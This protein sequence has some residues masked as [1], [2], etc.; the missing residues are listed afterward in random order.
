MLCAVTAASPYTTSLARTTISAKKPQPMQSTYSA[1][2]IL[3][4]RRA[5]VSGISVWAIYGLRCALRGGLPHDSSDC[6]DGDQD[7]QKH[8][9]APWLDRCDGRVRPPS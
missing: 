1:P 9:Y 5:D 4:L 8:P 6:D 2:E 3:A 7:S